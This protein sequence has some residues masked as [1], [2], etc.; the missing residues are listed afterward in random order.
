MRWP[1]G[2]CAALKPL[3]AAGGRAIEALIINALL[4]M[5]AVTLRRHRVQRNLF[6]VIVSAASTAF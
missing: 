1:R 3:L 6:A 2:C 4:T 5:M